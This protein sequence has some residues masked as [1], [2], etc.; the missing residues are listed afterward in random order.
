MSLIPMRFR[1]LLVR[2]SNLPIRLLSFTD[3][4]GV[5]FALR[6][7]V[8][9][10]DWDRNPYLRLVGREALVFGAASSGPDSVAAR[11]PWGSKGQIVVYRRGIRRTDRVGRMA[12]VHFELDDSRTG[13][14]LV[15]IRTARKHALA[16]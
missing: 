13:R 10:C 6:R 1:I 14:I 8:A 5:G 11:I 3:D 7:M 12:V 9:L 15:P 2:L 16:T 4:V